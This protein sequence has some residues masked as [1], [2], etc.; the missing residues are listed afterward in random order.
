M[1]GARQRRHF[2]L[3]QTLGGEADHLAQ[4]I[5]V[6]RASPRAREG[7]S[8]RWSSV[9]PRLRL[10][11]APILPA[12]TDPTGESPVTTATA[13]YGAIEGAPRERQKTKN[14]HHLMP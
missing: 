13:R 3:H 2:H 1:T 10:S 9:V 5:G 14:L 12:S 8:S 6:G 11:V 4:N 7:S